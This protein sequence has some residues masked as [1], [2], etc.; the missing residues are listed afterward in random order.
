MSAA[1]VRFNRPKRSDVAAVLVA[2]LVAIGALV[3]WLVAFRDDPARTGV[4]VP[5]PG[6]AAFG[7]PGATAQRIAASDVTCAWR[8]DGHVQM[9]IRLR[10]RQDVP[11]VI[12]VTP[13]YSVGGVGRG[14][15]KIFQFEIH[16]RA[17]VSWVHDLGAPDQVS[18]RTPFT[19]CNPL[20]SAL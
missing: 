2:G 8:A 9:Q 16:P 14:W 15:D 17:T 19:A 1:P 7:E 13:T 18:D 12:R 3:V 5:Y 10:N 11:H 20:V 4:G 6:A